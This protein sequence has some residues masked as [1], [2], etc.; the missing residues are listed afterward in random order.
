MPIDPGRT[1]NDDDGLASFSPCSFAA[2][3]F[4]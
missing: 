2:S 3:Y 1:N 4:V